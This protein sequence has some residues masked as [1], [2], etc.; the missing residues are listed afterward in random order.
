MCGAYGLGGFSGFKS[1]INILLRFSLQNEPEVKETL[2]I[3]PSMK[4]IVVTRNSPN[5]GQILPFGFEVNWFIK[6]KPVTKLLINAKS[7][8]VSQL[9]T[10]K[11]MFEESRC[12]VPASFYFE[13]KK[14]DD[15]TKTPYCFKVKNNE[16]FSI[17]GIYNDKGFVILT[18]KPN[19]LGAKVHDRMP[20]ILKKD[21]EDIW[22]NPESTESE[23]TDLFAPYPEKE[24]EAYPVSTLVNSASNQSEEIIKPLKN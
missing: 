10:Y 5:K 11:K 9:R 3:R 6:G 14:N 13:W 2:N 1:S 20:V 15:G 21:D 12:L 19:K 18:T 16:V 22:L 23:L 8:T 4:S 7:E 24:M 17:A